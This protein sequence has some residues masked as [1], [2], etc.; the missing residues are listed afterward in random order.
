M[1]IAA[2]LRL[3]VVMGLWAACFP[4]ITIGLDLVPHL[5]FAAMRAALAG[6]RVIPL[7][8]ESGGIP[9]GLDL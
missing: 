1:P 4:L 2:A 8:I 6:L 9:L 7:L 5:A 3:L